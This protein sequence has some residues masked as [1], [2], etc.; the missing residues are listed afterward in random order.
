MRSLSTIIKLRIGLLFRPKV[1]RTY[2]CCGAASRAKPPER[3]SLALFRPF[4][5]QMA[6]ILPAAR[7]DSPYPA[8]PLRGAWELD[9]LRQMAAGQAGRPGSRARA[10]G[11]A[12]RPGGHRRA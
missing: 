10:C 5:N 8:I 2:P 1:A 4:P 9:A 12:R 3:A 7:P 6:V 11:L